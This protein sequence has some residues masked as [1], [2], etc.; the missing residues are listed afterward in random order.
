MLLH[1]N[2]LRNFFHQ[3]RSLASLIF[4]L[5]FIGHQLPALTQQVGE[6][7]VFK[8]FG[9]T[10]LYLY[11]IFPESENPSAGYR[12][13]MVFFFGG[14]WK[15]GT[16]EQFRPHA[17]YFASRNI[18]TFLAE[19]R[20]E[21]RHGSTPF[22][23]VDDA[24]S[25]IQFIRE[26][27]PKWS[28]DQNKI[29]AAGGSAG[30]HIAAAA[31]LVEQSNSV[32][33]IPVISSEPD[34]LVLFNPVYDNGP[35]GYGYD[36]IGDRY[37]EISPIHNISRDEPPT[38]VFFGTE[39]PL[40]P[41]STAERFCHLMS[42]AENDC[43]LFLYPEQKHGFFN[44]RFPKYYQETVYQT[45]LFLVEH[46]FIEGSPSIYP[47]TFF[48][49]L[50]HAHND[51][52][53]ER[54]LQ[55]ALSQG[56]ASVE[57]DILY[58]KDTL[59]VGHDAEELDHDA[60][61]ILEQLYLQP[62]YQR[63]RDFGHI[64]PSLQDE[65]FYLWIDI[66]YAPEKVYP[67]LK[68]LIRPYREMFTRREGGR[69]IKSAVR[70]ILSGDRPIDQMLAEEN[71]YFFLDGRRQNILS[72]WTPA[73]MPFISENVENIAGTTADDQ[74]S[75]MQLKEIAKFIDHCHER[76]Y[77]VRFWNTP[78]HVNCWRQLHELEVDLINTDQLRELRCFLISR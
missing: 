21:S 39:D 13:A 11:P 47:D 78:D 56:F 20:V 60:P 28:I 27:S 68:Q 43:K 62:L 44:F 74:F 69:V 50:A 34:A 37:R 52:R 58:R 26:N 66:K 51:Y 72:D 70:V 71:S 64:F 41:V 25:A 63:F 23:A 33:N 3:L 30:G 42:K 46:G 59:F 54:P 31:G 48:L 14:G 77:K 12:S 15:G 65:E 24:R 17:Q 67:L 76:N 6:E 75:D 36:R 9:D 18:V 38:I 53:H 19:Y 32:G 10:T 16:V 1:S 73:V 49:P 8:S 2:S 61:P 57:A 55:D 35:G 40:V 45:D 7:I 5:F 29:I 22:D 4:T